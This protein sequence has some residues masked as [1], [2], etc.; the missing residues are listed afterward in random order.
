A[1]AGRTAPAPATVAAARTIGPARH[2][3][4][5]I[6]ILAPGAAAGAPPALPAAGRP[7]VRLL[8]LPLSLLLRLFARA[9]TLFGLPAPDLGDPLS[10]R[11]L[12]TFRRS[13]GVVEPLDRH[14]AKLLPHR[15]L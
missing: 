7:P 1:A 10:D 12:E 13:G 5:S 8:Q 9:G 2:C 6:A 14:A 11:H 15:P 4:L 3:R